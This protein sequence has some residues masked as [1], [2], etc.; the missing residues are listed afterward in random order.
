MEF[1]EREPRDAVLRGRKNLKD[2]ND[3]MESMNLKQAMILESLTPEYATMDFICR[4]LKKNDRVS[5]TW[6]FNGEL[7]LKV[8][9][10]D[11]KFNICQINDLYRLFGASIIDANLTQPSR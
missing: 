9:E 3:E 7:W 1:R 11:E 5:Q 10:T 4:R 6:F 8:F 2:K